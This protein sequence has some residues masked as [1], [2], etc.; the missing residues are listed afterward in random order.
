[1]RSTPSVSCSA[2]IRMKTS[3]RSSAAMSCAWPGR[4][5]LT[6]SRPGE[7]YFSALGEFGEDAEGPSC[8]VVEGRSAANAEAVAKSARSREER[9][10]NDADFSL[11]RGEGE[12]LGV[13]AL[14]HLAPEEK[15]AGR[16][17][18]ADVA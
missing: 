7:S 6:S 16:I 14:G 2:A 12:G 18:H 13:K 3:A 11:Q 5:W 15:A 4:T 1:G 8:R 17:G 10:G 9:P